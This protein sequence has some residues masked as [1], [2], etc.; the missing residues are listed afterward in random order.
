MELQ[1]ILTKGTITEKKALFSFNVEES[2]EKILVKFNIW[3]REYFAVYFTSKDAPFHREIDLY[4]LQ[5]YKGDLKA[6]V[7]IAFRGAAKTA[8]TK[9]FLGF[10][11]ANDTSHY[12]KYIKILSADGD[13][14]KQITTDVYNMLV[15]PRIKEM[16]P[17]VF[18]KT[19]AKREETMSSFTTTT[20]VKVIAGTV[21]Q[22][23]RGA[24]QDESRPDWIWFEDFENRKT[25]RS[26]RVSTSIWENMEEARTGL[27]QDGSC[28]YTCNYISEM[29][30]VHTLVSKV[31][32]QKKVLIVPIIENGVPTWSRYTLGEIET[33]REQDDDF[34]G[35][36][37]CKPSA[38]RDV[39][40][41]RT[42]LEDMKPTEPLRE[43]ATFKIFKEFDPS[44]MY[45]SG[46]D[47]AGG[48]GLD[49]S[50][51]VFIDFSSYP[52]KVVAT[53]HSNTIKPEPFGDEIYREQ[54]IFGGCIAGIENNKFDQS[55]LK[56]KI[57]GAN[58]FSMPDKGTKIHGGTPKDY[59]WS[60][61]SLT[62]TQMMSSLS[63]VIEDGLLDLSDKMLIEE[64]KN[65]TRND[66]MDR[67]TDPRLTT[68]HFDLLVACAIAWQM[69]DYATVEEEDFYIE[70]TQPLYSDIGI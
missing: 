16:Y 26:A 33:M 38:S 20:G 32:D 8:R 11:I 39:Y 22:D 29:G 55:I 68:R 2:N 58:L 57:L 36:R 59:G 35:E 28:I 41:D 27:S 7:N 17:E 54:Q 30:N 53:F 63:K 52:A 4:N 70:E 25:L 6:F 60:T 31:S 23:Q 69:K 62:K 3:M 10:V 40:F 43:S 64:A 66:S 65:Y 9:L 44:H 1:E 51:S 34:E 49:S 48:V 37:L 67:P 46:H 15:Q 50:T 42:R 5:A 45:G 24:I 47:V 19:T 13:N 61:N 18:E 14:S 12:R 21:G 56:A